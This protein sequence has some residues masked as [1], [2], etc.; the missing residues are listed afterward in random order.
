MKKFLGILVAAGLLLTL[1][2]CAQPSYG[3]T[4]SGETVPQTEENEWGITLSAEDVTPTGMTLVCTQSGG[5]AKGI[6][7]TG[8]PF[9]IEREE[10]GV[11]LP[12]GTQPGLDWAWTMEGWIIEPN[13]QTK[14][15]VDWEWLYGHLEPGTYRMSKEIMDFR[16]PGDYDEQICTAEFAIV[17]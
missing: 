4:A 12:V 14:W 2:S 6:L 7:E 11:W 13:A 15:K 17:D 5:T 9:A 16:G 8:S 10:N 1:A 3:P